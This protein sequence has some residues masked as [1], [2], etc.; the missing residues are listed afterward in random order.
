MFPSKKQK[1]TLFTL[2]IQF[3]EFSRRTDK[4]A[5]WLLDVHEVIF[6]DGMIII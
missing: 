2:S 1:W 4:L 6:C 5:I 3:M